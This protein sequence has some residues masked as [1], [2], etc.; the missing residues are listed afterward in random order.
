MGFLTR[1]VSGVDVVYRKCIWSDPL[2]EVYTDG[3]CTECVHLD[4]TL[5]LDTRPNSTQA[6]CIFSCPDGY[7]RISP[8]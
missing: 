4:P 5:I 2:C 6:S 1:N 3:N 7:N 8:Y